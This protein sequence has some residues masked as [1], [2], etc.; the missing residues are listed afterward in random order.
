MS[1]SS[2]VGGHDL[3]RTFFDVDALAHAL[4][5]DRF[6]YT[7]RRSGQRRPPGGEYSPPPFVLQS[8]QWSSSSLSGVRGR[9]SGASEVGSGR[10][11]DGGIDIAGSMPPPPARTPE[12]RVDAG[13]Q[14]AAPGVAHSGSSPPTVRD[15]VGG[16]W[17]SVRRVGDRLRADY[18][19]GRGVFTGRTPVETQAVEG[20][21]GPPSLHMAGRMLGLS[22]VETRRSLVLEAAGTS[23]DMLRG[24]QFTSGDEGL[25][26]RPG[27]RRQHGLSEV[28]ARLA[29]G[30]AGAQAILDAIQREREMGIVA[31][32]AEDE[33]ADTESEP[34]EIAARRHRAQVAAAAAAAQATY[35]SGARGTGAGG[36][37]GRRGGPHGRPS[38]GRGRARSGGR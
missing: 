12:A 5:D 33:D 6:A 4:T 20:G 38:S 13:D 11:S 26:M 7:G 10:R 25:L 22:R 31:R 3:A 27:T 34:I 2:F 29:A 15:G 8:P 14:T 35:L 32:A 23:T 24:E 21:S 28:E 36:R 18:D 17:L 16:G 1:L 19:V 37:G 30:V 9:E